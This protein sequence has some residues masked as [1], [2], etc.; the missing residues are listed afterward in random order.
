MV[1][2]AFFDIDGTLVSFQTHVVSEETVRVIRQLRAQG[3]KV[4]IASGRHVLWINNLG[5]LEVDGYVALNGGYYVSGEGEV[6]Y[7]RQIPPGD[8]RQLLDYQREHP[9]PCSCV[10]D[11]IILTN[12]RNEVVDEVYRQ[13]HILN[14]PIGPIEGIADKRV[15]QLIAFFTAEEE[16]RIMAHMPHCVAT[17]WHPLFADVVPEGSNKAVGI[18]HLLV[19]YGIDPKET[20][21]FGDGGNDIE[22]L[23]YVGI[24]VA[25]GNASDEVKAAA[26]FVT[27]SVDDEG[28]AYGL[29]HFGLI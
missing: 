26:D 23:R 24:G 25:M 21:A 13:L 29:K 2:A 3:V 12:F 14:P 6:V 10:M 4:F 11:D 15:Y 1:K 18:Q 17:R 9:F 28:I 19:H 27:T 16:P 7:R 5:D 22:M 20:I 8:I